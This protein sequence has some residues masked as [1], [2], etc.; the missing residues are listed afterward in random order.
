MAG[1]LLKTSQFLE[2]YQQIILGV[3]DVNPDAADRICDAV[4]RGMNTGGCNPFR[5]VEL[6][7]LPRVARCREQP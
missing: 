6:S 7:V 3:T 2:D 5:V 1:A 4:D